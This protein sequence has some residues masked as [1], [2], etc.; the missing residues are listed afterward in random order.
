MK[1]FSIV[2]FSAGILLAGA[3]SPAAAAASQ[4]T[5]G[6]ID[7]PGYQFAV[8][9]TGWAPNASVTF[10]LKLGAN[11]YGLELTTTKDGTFVVG[12][13]KVDFCHG[14][15][16]WARDFS[17]NRASGPVGDPYCA[18]HASTSK[19][20]VL[21]GTRITP[22]VWR[23][24]GLPGSK[25]TTIVVADALYLWEKGTASPDFMLNAP[26][27]YFTLIG[28]GQAPSPTCSKSACGPGF[29]WE[30]IGMK[31]GSTDIVLSPWCNGNPCPEQYVVAVPVT[32]KA[33]SGT[34]A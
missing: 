1:L 16:Y 13:K 7:V 29:Y 15:M 12:A 27:E 32:I 6:P 21:A 20:V 23:R 5:I 4:P 33:R 26:D 10:T 25:A 24:Y 30:W 11:T 34:G 19:L 28:Q 17:G 9:G 14:S 8:Q 31:P 22:K 18:P 2:V 3:S